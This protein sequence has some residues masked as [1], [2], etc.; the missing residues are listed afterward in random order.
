MVLDNAV[1]RARQAI[2]EGRDAI[3]GMRSSAEIKDDLAEA[4]RAAGER[5]ASEGTAEY[6]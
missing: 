3:Q 6:R 5:F 2:V 1:E 4:L